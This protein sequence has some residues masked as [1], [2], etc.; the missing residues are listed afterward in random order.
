MRSMAA[1]PLFDH[2]AE[3]AHQRDIEENLAPDEAPEKSAVPKGAETV[4]VDG[5]E[6]S[7][8]DIAAAANRPGPNIVE[9][10]EASDAEAVEETV[11]V[12]LVDDAPVEEVSVGVPGVSPDADY[13]TVVDDVV[14]DDRD[15]EVSVEAVVIKVTSSPVELP[16]AVGE[17]VAATPYAEV[18]S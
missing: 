8:E 16:R 6:V 17:L 15:E 12:A 11:S 4:T 7:P 2:D 18:V 3:V 14:V 13:A 9:E 1:E 10:V 5:E